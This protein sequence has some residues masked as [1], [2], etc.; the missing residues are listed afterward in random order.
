[1]LATV[2]SIK[3]H[4]QS[5]GLLLA[6]WWHSWLASIITSAH[7]SLSRGFCFY[8][9][10]P[11]ENTVPQIPTHTCSNT[12]AISGRLPQKARSLGSGDGIWWS[13][14]ARRALSCKAESCRQVVLASP[15]KRD[16]AM[17]WIDTLLLRGHQRC[18]TQA[19]MREKLK[20]KH[21]KGKGQE[22]DE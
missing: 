14:S 3:E 9:R 21:M 15:T 22:K 4:K 19:L 1:M 2:I 5:H 6:R 10:H 7:Q 17:A 13:L 16:C 11:T 20:W 18:V 8:H 12:T